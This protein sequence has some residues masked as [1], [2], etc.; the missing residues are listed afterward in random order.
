MPT[1]Y[2]HHISQ[3]MP[4]PAQYRLQSSTRNSSDS[5]ISSFSQHQLC[6][7]PRRIRCHTH[8]DVA[9]SAHGY[10]TTNPVNLTYHWHRNRS[11]Y[12]LKD[13]ALQ[14]FEQKAAWVPTNT[15]ITP[16]WK[17]ALLQ[18]GT[19]SPPLVFLRRGPQRDL[20]LP[21]E[22]T[23][24]G[25]CRDKGDR[26]AQ[27]QAASS[28]VDGVSSGSV[29]ILT[30]SFEGLYY[31]LARPTYRTIATSPLGWRFV[32]IIFHTFF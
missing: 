27:K 9:L 1:I 2:H 7:G 23:L 6:L 32:L 10:L 12:Y 13:L 14:V 16:K 31:G 26:K 18:G 5:S 22:Q 29:I 25:T 28:H 4:E 24:S 8:R 3:K 20:Q 15:K 19:I 30:L 17:G 21:D 11:K